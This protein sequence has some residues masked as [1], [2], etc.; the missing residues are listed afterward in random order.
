MTCLVY[1]LFQTISIY[2]TIY[3]YDLTYPQVL[4]ISK[5]RLEDAVSVGRACEEL[6][7][8]KSLD[9][10]QNSF[11]TLPEGS[12]VNLKTLQMLNLGSNSIQTVNPR[13][14]THLPALRKVDLS[15]NELRNFPKMF[16]DS[17]PLLEELR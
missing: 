16:F 13:S 15:G 8:L 10:S 7:S 12:F 4:S 9:L 3:I 17:S 11:K 14:F 2:V 1:L 6:L 5:N